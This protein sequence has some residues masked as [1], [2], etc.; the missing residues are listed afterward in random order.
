MDTANFRV[1]LP[2]DIRP[3][4]VPRRPRDLPGDIHR[5]E[6]MLTSGGDER[7]AAD[8]VTGRNR[9]GTP[10]GVAPGEVWLASS[11]ASALSPRGHA[12]AR[13]SLAALLDGPAGSSLPAWFES[14]RAR[15]LALFG[16]AGCE[17]V[18]SAS[19][20]EAEFIV[21]LLARSLL[22]RPLSS[23]VLAPEETG[24]GVVL[25][26]GG[27][28][29]L[30]SSPFATDRVTRGAMLAGW[31][32]GDVEVEPLAIRDPQGLPLSADRIDRDVAAQVEASIAAGRDVLVHLLDCSKTGRSG[33]RRATAAALLERYAGRLLVVVDACQLR[34]PAEQI[35]AD[36]GAGFMVMITGSKFAGGPPFAGALLLP[37]PLAAR[38][39]EISPPPGLAAYSAALD[40]PQRF[41][42]PLAGAFTAPANIG[43]GLRWEAALTELEALASLDGILHRHIVAR[44]GALVRAGI[45]ATPGLEFVD[46]LW[47]CDC[48]GTRTI[49]PVLTSDAN[50]RPVP[51]ERLHRALR[52]PERGPA[53]GATARIFH[54]GQPVRVGA[55]TALRIVLSAVQMVDIGERIRAGQDFDA[56]FAP[57]AADIAALF[58]AWAA[59]RGAWS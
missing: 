23:I 29:F 27:R 46:D 38:L 19:G 47:R 30:G 6:L 16:C 53:S 7:I 10:R 49:F 36:L 54:L 17:A 11:T 28:H 34:C 1:A 39:H 57:L 31:E 51:A 20:T 40:W 33:L 32:D 22:A 9:Y 45:A 13:K 58:D 56:A 26:A 42:P 55:R 43:L 59:L 5:L 24:S 4:P 41:T 14:L 35:R 52:D 44:F 15:L 48:A 18:L 2:V 12:A 50:R 8:P 37:P 3:D 25:A 21:L